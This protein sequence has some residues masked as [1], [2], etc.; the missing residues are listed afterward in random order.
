MREVRDKAIGIDNYL[1]NNKKKKR[2][3]GKKKS[4]EVLR[5]YIE[6]LWV[7]E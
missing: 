5:K 6:S 3:K 2:A 7:E 4:W 1:F